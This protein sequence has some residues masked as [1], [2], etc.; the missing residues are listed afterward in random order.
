MDIVFE[1]CRDF[2]GIVP[3][4]LVRQNIVANFEGRTAG[5]CEQRTEETADQASG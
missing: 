5:I 3:Q 2:S 1:A 4:L